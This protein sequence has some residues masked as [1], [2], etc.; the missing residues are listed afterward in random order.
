MQVRRSAAR[1]GA[2]AT[3]LALA[4][5][6]WSAGPAAAAAAKTKL[7]ACVTKSFSTLNLTTR[8]AKCRA[9]EL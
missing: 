1:C 2:L 9:G 8:A 6:A 5:L 7:Y 3:I 4:A